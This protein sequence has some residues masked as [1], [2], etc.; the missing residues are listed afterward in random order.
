MVS[1]SLLGLNLFCATI[2]AITQKALWPTKGIGEGYR[3]WVVSMCT[4]SSKETLNQK[5]S[6]GV[7]WSKISHCV[8]LSPRN[9]LL[10][11]SCMWNISRTVPSRFCVP[12]KPKTNKSLTQISLKGVQGHRNIFRFHSCN[13]HTQ[14]SHKGGATRLHKII[15]FTPKWV[16]S[17]GKMLPISAFHSGTQGEAEYNVFEP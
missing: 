9:M 1:A 11:I 8:L 12:N 7:D 4:T 14:F 16:M 10:M 15:I 3:N 2:Q 5:G 17:Q 13:M 6:K